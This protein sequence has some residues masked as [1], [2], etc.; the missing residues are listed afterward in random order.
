MKYCTKCVLPDTTDAI[1]FDQDG[2]C[3]VCRAAEV[4]KSKID[5]QERGKMLARIIEKHKDK[6][7]YDCIVPFS[8]GKDSVFQLWYVV[9]VLGIKPLVVRYNHWGFRPIIYKNCDK[10][11]KKLGVDVVEFQA[12]WHVVKKLMKHALEK[13]GDSC[14]HCHLGVFANTLRLAIKFNIPLII[15]GESSAE[16]AGHL[17][18]EEIQSANTE[19][20]NKIVNLGIDADTMYEQL[21]GQI[22]KRELIKYTVPTQEELEKAGIEAIWLGNYIKWDTK[23]NVETIKKELGWEGVPV[24]GIPPQYD[25]EKIECMWQGVRD[26]CKYI[27]RGNGRT[28]HLCCIDIRNGRMTRDE[29]VEL[30]KQYDGKRPASLDLY[31]Q[32]LELTEDE[33]IKILQKNQVYDWGFDANKIEKGQ[34]LP[35]MKYWSRE[36]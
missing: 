27:K 8:G 10:V 32:M 4:K 3:N 16:Y 1:A 31:L 34:E 19:F 18:F 17:S 30:C 36:F 28:N 6:G 2:V 26:Y 13:T 9:R 5:W 25:Y 12:N 33:F 23:S 7:E 21:N 29:A 14:W 22:E 11:F 35:D 20:F 24:E 15:Y